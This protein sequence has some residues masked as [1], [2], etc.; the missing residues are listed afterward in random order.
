MHNKQLGDRIIYLHKEITLIRVL[1]NGIGGQ[2]GNALQDQFRSNDAFL[3]LGL[4]KE[5]LDLT[6][7]AGAEQLFERHQPDYF[8]H[9][10]AYTAVDKAQEDVETCMNIN[11]KATGELAELCKKY[12]TRLI[13][14]SS[15]YVYHSI[16]DRPIVETDPTTPQGVYAKSKFEGEE[17]IRK[18][19]DKHYIFRTSWV[20]APNGKNFVRTMLRLGPDKDALN[21]VADQTGAPTYAPDIARHLI[22]VIHKERNAD[23]AHYG[24]Y[25]FTNGGQTNW[26]DLTRFIFENEGINCIVNDTT[27]AAY[28]APAPRPHWSVL[29]NTKLEKTFNIRFPNWDESVR[30]CLNV[31]K[32]QQVKT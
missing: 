12:D 10:A 23:R 15:D 13:Y 22:E 2:V 25:N 17:Q 20:Y 5:E 24:T 31:I 11:A 16:H 27:T 21:I 19:W 26:A 1:Y 6:T 18:T 3:A 29:D 28:G 14:I 8:L 30:T 32:T 7:M 9:V 4:S